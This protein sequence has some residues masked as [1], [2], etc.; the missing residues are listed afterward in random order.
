MEFYGPIFSAQGTYQDS[1]HIYAILKISAPS[2][3]EEVHSFL[4][5]V[6]YSSKYSKDYATL[7]PPNHKLPKKSVAFTW[8]TEHQTAIEQLKLTLKK[9]L[10]WDILIYLKT[11]TVLWMLVLWVCPQFYRNVNQVQ[12]ITK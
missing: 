5:M 2:N 9:Y 4:G 12:V 10:S 6:N 8:T 1:K 7:P 11:R 3:A